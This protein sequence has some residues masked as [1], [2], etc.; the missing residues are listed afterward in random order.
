MNA[1][2]LINSILVA[3]QLPN[4][5][6]QPRICILVNYALYSLKDSPALWYKEFATTLTKNGLKA[7]K[8][9]LYIFADLEH[10]VF[11][12]FYIDNV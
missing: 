5:F 3:C 7:L 4:G 11:V 8:E 1:K 10:K 12:V 6:K 9:E 2:R